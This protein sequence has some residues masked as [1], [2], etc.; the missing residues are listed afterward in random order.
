M[1]GSE[2]LLLHGTWIQYEPTVERPRNTASPEEIPS[3]AMSSQCQ[4]TMALQFGGH[5]E[6][7]R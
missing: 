4:R 6:V 1:R 7:P 2:L 5:R 3:R